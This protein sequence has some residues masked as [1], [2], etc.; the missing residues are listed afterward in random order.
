MITLLISIVS[1]IAL[2]LQVLHLINWIKRKKNNNKGKLLASNFQS[3]IRIIG[4]LLMIFIIFLYS[5]FKYLN[6]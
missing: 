2:V 1:L 5:T 3:I 4:V 6:A